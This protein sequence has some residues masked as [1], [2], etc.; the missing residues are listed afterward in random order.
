M[1]LL[2]LF[3]VQLKANI[4]VRLTIQTIFV[5]FEISSLFIV[6]VHIVVDEIKGQQPL[7]NGIFPENDLVNIE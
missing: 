1:I 7:N 6:T 2:V 3:E 5:F 4:Y